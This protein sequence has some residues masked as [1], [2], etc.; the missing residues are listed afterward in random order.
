MVGAQH[1]LERR[2]PRR[3]TRSSVKFGGGKEEDWATTL[4][5]ER[6][7]SALRDCFINHIGGVQPASIATPADSKANKRSATT[8]EQPHTLL[9]LRKP[10]IVNHKAIWFGVPNAATVSVRWDVCSE[11][12]WIFVHGRIFH[13]GVLLE[14]VGL[15]RCHGS[16]RDQ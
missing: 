5:D 8:L 7:V 1:R 9:F 6:D 10:Q 2:T 15:S 12:T 3:P 13:G 14:A 11:Q 4:P 16:N